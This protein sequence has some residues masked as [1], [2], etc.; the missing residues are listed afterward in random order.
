MKLYFPTRQRAREFAR[1]SPNYVVVDARKSTKS[2]RWSVNVK[3][4]A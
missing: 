4:E 3:P 1:K 2:H